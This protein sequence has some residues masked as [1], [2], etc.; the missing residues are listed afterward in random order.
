MG[1]GPYRE[2]RGCK[3]AHCSVRASPFPFRLGR[4]AIPQYN[5]DVPDT[6]ASHEVTRILEAIHR[7]EVQATE[8][9]LPVVYGELRRLA[10]HKMSGEA[11]G[12]TLQP[13]ALVH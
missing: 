12:H 5:W 7:G 2:S 13:T 3:S 9:L 4:T 11:V 6:P 1:H 8:E 10:A